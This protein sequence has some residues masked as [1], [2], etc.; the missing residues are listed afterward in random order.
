MKLSNVAIGVVAVGVSLSS[1]TSRGAPAA[2]VRYTDVTPD[3]MI[4]AAKA[5]ALTAGAQD[6]AVLGAIAT[7]VSLSERA[8][9]GASEKALAAIA[10]QASIAQEVRDEAALTK[11]AMS[12]DEGET[13]GIAADVALGVLTHT[14]ILGPF[15]DT[16]GGLV[17]KEGPEAKGAA[18]FDP[19]EDDS[20]GT[21]Q[22]AWREVPESYSQAGGTPLDVFIEPRKESC[23]YIGSRVELAKAGPIVLHLA[24]TGQ[25]RLMFDGADVGK[26]EDSNASMEFDRIAATV[27]ATPGEHVVMAKVCTGALDDD[28]RVRLRLTGA[29]GWKS[30]IQP[31]KGAI[32]I[33]KQAI[34]TTATPLE[35]VI[36]GG[37]K[38]A[39]A[40]ELL[41]VILMRTLAGADDAKSPRAPGLLDQL[42]HLVPDDADRLAMAGWVAPSG[43][44]RSGWLHD[45]AVAAKKTNDD[46]AHKFAIRRLIAQHLQARMPDWARAEANVALRGDTDAEAVLTNAIVDEGLGVESLRLDALRALEAYADAHA[47]APTALLQ[48]LAKLALSFDAARTYQTRDKL[49]ARGARGLQWVEAVARHGTQKDVVS[50]AG[51]AL[52]SGSVEDADDVIRIVRAVGS[53]GAHDEAL[54]FSAIAIAMA[55]NED[56]AWSML[57]EQTRG[58]D[59][60]KAKRVAGAL[61]APSPEALVDAALRRAREL[62]PGDARYRAQLALAEAGLRGKHTVVAPVT[63]DDEKYIVDAKTILARRVPVPPQPDVA[64]RQLH[65]L[66]AVVM[67]D[68]GASRSSSTTRAR[69]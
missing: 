50:A 53:A 25:A 38:G 29:S 54:Q 20:W 66:R 12:P 7:I 33:G 16:G 51:H 39:G 9:D 47:D 63:H 69:S 30:D 14:A 11:R 62:A 43:A 35:H 13:A 5:R 19:K 34:R 44:N 48:E 45:A 31:P 59:R 17:R 10:A 32:A 58:A 8:T 57:A 23:S 4:D 1:S 42:T 27:E 55:P 28:G 46:R 52:R 68:D 18:P 21:V 61:G 41:D 24:A 36:S 40:D 67:H 56:D 60:E 64:D 6:H 15:R 37:K 22:V 65:W 49:H 3:A 2:V 26:N